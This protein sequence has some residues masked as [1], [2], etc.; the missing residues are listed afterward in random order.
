MFHCPVLS[1]T[2]TV[3]TTKGQLPGN[4]KSFILHGTMSTKEA[5]T[6]EER[7]WGRKLAMSAIIVILKLSK[8]NFTS[9]VND[10][11]K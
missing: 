10:K 5:V 9:E 6:K 11:G 7:Y 1:H 8:T 4:T 3:A 2:I